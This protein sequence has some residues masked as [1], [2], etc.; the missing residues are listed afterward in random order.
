[1]SKKH[2]FHDD[3]EMLSMREVRRSA[4]IEGILHF[5]GMPLAI[6]AVV[7][8]FMFFVN[9]A[10]S[11]MDSDRAFAERMHH[12]KDVDVAQASSQS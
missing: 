10:L 8:V 5:V 9:S 6:L 4:A 2:K 11:P 12:S 1:M 3:D 7:G